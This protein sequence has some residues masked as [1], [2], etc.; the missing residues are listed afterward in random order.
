MK[1][2]IVGMAL[3]V[4]CSGTVMATGASQGSGMQGGQEGMQR[5]QGMPHGQGM[6]GQEPGPQAGMFPH[7]GNIDTNGDGY[8]SKAEI[9]VH[10]EQLRSQEQF[11]QELADEADKSPDGRISAAEFAAMEQKQEQD[12]QQ[13]Q[14]NQ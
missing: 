13:Q 4:L 6:Q 9:Q 5:Q 12:Q 1:H 7:F 8:L 10:Q 2:S 3:A 11:L 14:P